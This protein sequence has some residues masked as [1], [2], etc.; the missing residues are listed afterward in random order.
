VFADRHGQCVHLVER[1]CSVQRRHQKVLEE[2]PA[3][4]MTAAQRQ[5]MGDAAVAAAKAVG[6]VGA[7]TVEFLRAADGA[8]F[9]MEMNTRLQVEHPVTEMITGLDLV[10]WQL[11]VASGEPLPLSQEQIS[12]RGHAIEARIYAEDPARDFMPSTGRLVHLALPAPSAHVRVDSGVAQGDEITPW[13]DPMIAKLI[14]WDESR[15]LALARLGEALG[16]FHI[17]GVANN[18]PFLARLVRTPSF[19]GARLD[20]Q[21]IER[22]HD[23]LFPADTSPPH[24]VVLSAALAVLAQEKREAERSALRRT[25]PWSPWNARSGWRLNGK[26]ERILELVCGPHVS[27]LRVEYEGEHYRLW[28]DGAPHASPGSLE[29]DG[30]PIGA[31]V[32]FHDGRCYVFSGGETWSFVRADRL[33]GAARHDLADGALLAPMPGRVVALLVEAPAQVEKGAPLLVIEAMKMEHTIKAPAAGTLQ[34]HRFA[35]GDQ[36]PQGVQLVDFEATSG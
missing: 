35:V 6:Y 32:V 23:A 36:V 1:D 25:E 18:V 8:F 14:V 29:M 3:P 19:A 27:K 12:L 24:D 2:A 31:N 9:F 15:E 20:T 34:A 21:L 22:E 5:A 26:T 10:E 17:A 13:Y 7:G 30:A 11:R 4:G 28:L 16:A 33:E